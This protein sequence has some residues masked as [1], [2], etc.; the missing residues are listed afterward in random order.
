MLGP[1][2]VY[3]PNGW[4]PGPS[5]SR[6][7]LLIRMLACVP[8]RTVPITDIKRTLPDDLTHEAQL[9]RVHMIA[10]GARCYLRILLGGFDSIRSTR[11]SYALHREV[12][13][14]SDFDAF[15]LAY[16]EGTIEALCRAEELV[17]GEF[18]SGE[19]GAWL[20]RPRADLAGKYTHLLEHLALY[21]YE[22]HRPERAIHF[23]TL[24]TGAD[25]SHEGAARL[26]M[27]SYA[28]LGLRSAALAEFE[29]LRQF[30]NMNLGARPA[31]ETRELY[32]ALAQQ[33]D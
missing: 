6:G 2:S 28:A 7:G 22:R 16:D 5:L 31:A 27:R 14:D 13:V 23:A 20:R 15:N 29:S 32:Y 1:F 17:G 9:H 25:R 24:L 8:S 11:N 10:S 30:L 19:S 18:L 26:I 3:G 4:E 12:L 21:N 33:G